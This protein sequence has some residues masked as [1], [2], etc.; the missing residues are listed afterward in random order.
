MKLKRRQER[1]NLP[2]TVT[3][4]VAED[5]SRVYVVG[6]AHFSDDSKKDVVKDTQSQVVP[7]SVVASSTELSPRR[8]T[9][10]GVALGVGLRVRRGSARGARGE[11]ACPSQTIREVQPDVVVVELCQYRVSMLK[12]DERTLLREAKEISLEKLQ[13][14]VRQLG[15]APGGEFREAFKEVGPGLAGGRRGLGTRELSGA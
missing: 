11:L 3:E 4:L 10:G 15:V 2:R 14:A 6:T 7:A 1:P 9:G 8:L 13:Q 5:G 12:M